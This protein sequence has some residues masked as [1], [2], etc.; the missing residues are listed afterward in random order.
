VVVLTAALSALAL[1]VSLGISGTSLVLPAAAEDLNLSIGGATWLLTVYGWGMAVSM[2]LAA[3]LAARRGKRLALGIGAALHV[4]GTAMLLTAPGVL[5]L[6][7]GRAAL[8]AGAGTMAVL[9]MGTARGVTPLK[10]RQR[11]LVVISASIG[12][13]GAAGPVV[14][15]LVADATSWRVATALPA[16][17]VLAVPAVACLTART[18]SVP[19]AREAAPA[20]TASRTSAGFDTTGAALLTGVVTALFIALQGPSG[21]LP[22]T[23][24]VAAVLAGLGAAAAL[25]LRVR[26]R[27]DGFLP[28]GIRRDRRFVGAAALVL[29]VAS[30]NFALIYA[31][32]QLLAE[33]TGW[34]RSQIGALLVAPTLAAATLSW[35]MGNVALRL[36]ARRAVLPIAALSATIAVIAGLTESLPAVLAAAAAGTFASAAAQGV[37]VADGTSALP[38]SLHSQA[39]GLFNLI[40]QFGS[41]VGP[42]VLATLAPGL[43]VGRALAVAAVLPLI[44]AAVGPRRPPEQNHTVQSGN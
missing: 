23:A 31:A 42:S 6:I 43:G 27:P 44:A 5:L 29:G 11:A 38:S 4:L 36:G 18:G 37:L 10:A 39:V 33:Q 30:L 28:A 20:Q 8:G 40:F 19:A 34:S 21:A 41:V 32:P 17:S 14:G 13:S 22:G 16:L 1:P 25:A 9:A 2:P 15:S 35:I 26:S 3:V 12:A 7:A 24:V